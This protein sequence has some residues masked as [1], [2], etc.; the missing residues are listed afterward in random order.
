VPSEIATPTTTT[1][2]GDLEPLDRGLG[3]EI[4][5]VC[6]LVDEGAQARFEL[7][8][9]ERIAGPQGEDV[10]HERFVENARAAHVERREA[11]RMP[12]WMTRSR[13]PG[14]VASGVNVARM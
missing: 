4:A 10:A 6:V 3:I 11:H 8:R 2:V 7:G 9:P 1:V 14:T 5:A 12:S 13:T